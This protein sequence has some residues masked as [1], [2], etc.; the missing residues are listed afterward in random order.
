[1]AKKPTD[2]HKP[3]PR[4]KSA[5]PEKKTSWK[6]L[7]ATGAA[8]VLAGSALFLASQPTASPSKTSN[9]AP[10]NPEISPYLT[11]EEAVAIY[12]D[13]EKQVV[14]KLKEAKT[15]GKTLRI[16][17]LEGHGSKNA[18]AYQMMLADIV[19]KHGI[20]TLAH[21]MS[22]TDLKEALSDPVDWKFP[23]GLPAQWY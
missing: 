19:A 11:V 7:V 6:P 22:P 17:V 15:Q 18:M 13:L 9:V 1:M 14:E 12:L 8:T 16:G 21:E 23:T 10:L 5:V 3:G 4:G 2:N 20:P